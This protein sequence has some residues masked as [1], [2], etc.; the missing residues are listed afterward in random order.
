MS[1]GTWRASDTQSG[2]CCAKIVARTAARI[3]ERSC[4]ELTLR[5]EKIAQS[6][7]KRTAGTSS[8]LWTLHFW[9]IELT[10]VVFRPTLSFS[11]RELK[12]WEDDE[13]KRRTESFTLSKAI[14]LLDWFFN[15]ENFAMYA[16]IYAKTKTKITCF[17]T[18][19]D[20]FIVH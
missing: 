9:S 17:P 20:N 11:I 2:F 1:S 8:C 13:R 14:F 19:L 7:W 18:A 6:Y 15:A 5:H 3:T 16:E 10:K 12:H 4:K